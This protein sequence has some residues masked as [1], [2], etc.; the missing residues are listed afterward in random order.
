MRDADDNA[1]D[2]E[3]DP[4]YRRESSDR[5]GGWGRIFTLLIA[6]GHRRSEIPYYTLP[7][8]W[9]YVRQISW[10]QRQDFARQIN[11]QVALKLEP[12]KLTRLLRKLEH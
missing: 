9:E 8:I 5:S 12:E 3:P 6:N 1:S 7:Q 11:A 10:L 4:R 2:E